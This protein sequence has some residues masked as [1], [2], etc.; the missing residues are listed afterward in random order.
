M[1]KTIKKLD[2]VSKKQE[3][4]KV[5]AYCRVSSD[6]DRL[7]HSLSAQVGYYNKLIQTNPEWEFAGI[8]SDEGISGT[9]IAKRKDFQ[10]MIAD[11]EAGKIDIILTKSI[12][13]FARNTVDLLNTVRHLKEIGVEVR[14]EKERINSMTGD[15]ELMLSILAS[16][17]QEEVNSLSQN[18]RWGAAKRM[19]SGKPHSHPRTFGYLWEGDVYVPVEPE[20]SAVTQMFQMYIDGKGQQ[21]IANWL[22]EKGITT[23]K[24]CK[25]DSTKVGVV[26][27]NISYTGNMLLGKVY[28]PTPMSRNTKPNKGQLPKYFVENSHEALITMEQFDAVQEEREKRKTGKS[29]RKSR[30]ERTFL[31]GILMDD[32][33]R[34][35]SVGSRKNFNGDHAWRINYNGQDRPDAKVFDSDLRNLCCEI[36][37][38]ENFEEEIVTDKIDSIVFKDN[39]L[40]FNF[41]SGESKTVPYIYKRKGYSPESKES[42]R[43]SIKVSWRDPERRQQRLDRLAETRR[44]KKCQQLQEE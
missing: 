17:A 32:N 14:F 3:R 41:K 15:G 33:G 27:A 35:F 30:A 25:W 11:A 37:G 2:V 9:G 6:S 29:M 16:F 21:E 31:N 8:Y 7:L 1:K 44:R 39:Y 28:S 26:L 23:V 19:S 24:G 10:R 43:N 20:A 4:Q 42:W 34:K 12:Q 38:M 18:V 36:L 40:T 13:R 22:N 5:A